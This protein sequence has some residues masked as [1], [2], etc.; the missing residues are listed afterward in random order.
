[1]RLCPFEQRIA[2]FAALQGSSAAPENLLHGVV[3]TANVEGMRSAV[4]PE[5]DEYAD[6]KLGTYAQ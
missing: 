5:S 2:T 3:A 4:S 6:V 1:M